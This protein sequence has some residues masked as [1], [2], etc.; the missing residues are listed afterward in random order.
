MNLQKEHY[1][2]ATSTH[3]PALEVKN[4]WAYKIEAILQGVSFSALVEHL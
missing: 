1:C 4:L 2:A 3:V